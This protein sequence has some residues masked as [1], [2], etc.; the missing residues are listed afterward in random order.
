MPPHVN[1]ASAP[2]GPRDFQ[3]YWNI[4]TFMC[5]KYGMDF[6]QVGRKFGILQN[7]R[8]KFRGDK[9]AILYDPGDFPA[10]L[11]DNTGGEYF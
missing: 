9:I 6:E 8:D 3:I 5:H 10:L 4:P 11:K 2:V 7:E 1:V